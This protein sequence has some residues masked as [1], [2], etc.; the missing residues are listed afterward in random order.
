V[1]G[2]VH[3]TEAIGDRQEAKV[4]THRIIKPFLER[5]WLI[6][7]TTLTVIIG[8][9]CW[10]Q[11][12]P[13]TYVSSL[14]LEATS[15]D[16]RSI[17]RG[18]VPRLYKELKSPPVFNQV[19]QSEPFKDQRESGALTEVL[20]ER[21]TSNIGL[22]EDFQGS[23]VVVHL[24]YLDVTPEAAEQGANVLGQ[25]I[26]SAELG[27]ES[28][29]GFAFKV[30]QPA[31]PA[32]G[33]IKPQRFMLTMFALGGGFLLGLVLAGVSELFKYRRHVKFDSPSVRAT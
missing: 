26:A 2:N 27:R 17:P 18:Q 13:D 1:T 5:R 3:S 31:S 4:T 30:L 14:F 11:R 20:A 33:P 25:A 28:E 16:G 24:R 10:S 29:N 32:I 22:Q 19:M 8:T 7:T 9:F 6:L 23:S 12:L 15:K 21:L